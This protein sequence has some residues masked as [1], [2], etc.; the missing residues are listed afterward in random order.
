MKL[1]YSVLT[2]FLVL[3]SVTFGQE[4]VFEG[5]I[6]DQ[7]EGKKLSG[8]SVK[9]IA[10]GSVA[11]STTTSGNGG[12]TVKMPIGKI[13]KI[14][15]SKPGYVTKTMSIDLRG[16]NGEDIPI[17]GRIMP[18]VDIELFK[19]R[20]GVDF[21]FLENEPVVT[22]EYD[23]RSLVMDWDRKVYNKMKKKIDDLLA[24]ADAKSKEK[25]A[26]YNRLIQEADAL[27]KEEK[28]NEAL[29]KY[30]ESIKIKGKETEAHPN[31]RIIEIENILQKKAEEELANKQANQAYQNLLD[32]AENLTKNKEYD[33][34]I[35]KYNEALK[36]K[37]GEQFP[38]DK[39]NEIKDL[40]QKESAE[41]EYNKLITEAD[42]L[43]KESK[44]NEARAKYVAA[45]KLL[46]DKAYP[47]DQLKA[48][49]EK[50]A[51][52]KN[53]QENKAK[54]DQAVASA[55][56]LFKENKFQEAIVKYQEA[57]GY[58]KDAS[59]PKDQIRIAEE[60]ISK[61][62]ALKK[63]K[64]EFDKL[65]IQADNLVSSEQYEDA[66]KTYNEA[67]KIMS[68]PEAV[69]KKEAAVKK[70]EELKKDTEKQEKIALL[71][72]SAKVSF[73]NK[74]Y[75]SALTGYESVLALDKNN[76]TAIEGK[77]KT[78]AEI[79]KN[80]EAEAT[81]K[82]FDE[83]VSTGDELFRQEKWEESQKMYQEANNVIKDNDHV[84]KR[85]ED[86]KQK[87]ESSK[88]LAEQNKKIESLFNKAAEDKAKNNWDAAIASYEEILSIDKNN[89]KASN[90]L[91]ET[92]KA[93]ENFLADKKQQEE[94]DKLK[95]EADQLFA[96]KK[97]EEAK[98]KYLAARDIKS[99]EEIKGKLEIIDL[100][101][102]KLSSQKEKEEKYQEAMKKAADFEGNKEYA[103]ALE[104]YK[105][106]LAYKEN[107]ATAINKKKELELK[108]AEIQ[109]E[110]EREEK[111]QAALKEGNSAFDKEDYSSAIKAYD[112]ALEI[113]PNGAEAIEMK[114]K[115]KEK[116]DLLAKSEESYQQLLANAK[117]KY[118]AGKL[119]EAR[120]LYSQA[121]DAKPSDPIPQKAIVE[122]DEKLR[123]K[124]EADANLKE[125][126]EINKK[127][128][129]KLDLAEVAAQNFKYQEAV[130]HLKEASKL[131][132]SEEFPKKKIK[133]YQALIDQIAAQNN[134]E[135]K[136]SDLIDKADREF[137][138]KNYK[139]S[140]DLY[141]EALGVKENDDYANAQIKKAEEAMILAEKEG[142]LEKYRNIIA[143]ANQEF[144][145][146]NYNK[147]LNLYKEALS[148]KP[149]DKFASDR[150]SETQQIL[151][152][153]AKEESLASEEN[154][155]FN[156][157][158]NEADKLFDQK[159][160]IKAKEKYEEALRIK[161]NDAYAIRRVEES[162]Q[163][164]KKKVTTGDEERY[165]KILTKADEYFDEENYTKAKS[166]YERALKLRNYDKY[167]KD[168]LAEIRAI[169]NPPAKNEVA[170]ENL[171]E[172]EGIS[173][174]EG[175]A[176][177]EQA[178]AQRK[179]ERT[180]NVL[181]EIEKN[182]L[183]FKQKN[184]SDYEEHLAYQNEIVRIRDS[185][186]EEFTQEKE[187]RL[188]VA[189]EIEDMEFSI[190]EQRIQEN[191]YERNEHLRGNEELTYIAD[192]Y[193][194]IQSEK[195]K[196]SFN[197]AEEINNILEDHQ[198]QLREEIFL[199][200][201]N[202]EKT[203]EQ[204]EEISEELSEK[205][206]LSKQEQ[207]ETI[208]KIKE[209]ENEYEAQSRAEALREKMDTQKSNQQLEVVAENVRDDAL[210]SVE[211][212]EENVEKIKAIEE[213]RDIKSRTEEEQ[214]YDKIQNI[215]D[216]ALLAELKQD[217]S[218]DEKA[219]IQEQLIN[220]IA[221]LEG[222]LKRKK[223]EEERQTYEESLR[224][225]ALLDRASEQY[226]E[227]Q[228][229]KDDARQETVQ[230]ITALEEEKAEQER[231]AVNEEKEEH[232]NSVEY[233]EKI[234]QLKQE[235]EQKM[236]ED[237]L[238][239]NEEV[240][241]QEDLLNRSEKL[242]SDEEQY[243]RRKTVSEIE[244]IEQK[245]KNTHLD[246]EELRKEN[247]E[248][249]KA[250]ETSINAGKNIRL[251]EEKNKKL[252]TQSY[253]DDLEN[254]K[255]DFDPVIA[256]S[257]GEDFPEGVSQETYVRRD[258]DGL[259]VRIVTRRIV[260]QD[261][262]GEVYIRIQTRNA[263]T[264]SKNGQPITEASWIKGTEN[265]NLEHHF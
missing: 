175:M 189:A 231:L 32:A 254:G 127:Y 37:P 54:Y 213:A 17:G 12:Y 217:E 9:A 178:E 144:N 71:L 93:K 210:R 236:K 173:I 264:Y 122:I 89:T 244:L 3:L 38:V 21:S 41:K 63:Q 101:L 158:I 118:D 114:K 112:D 130:D 128:Q 85:L 91:D 75:Q 113:K 34:A 168:R 87:I 129:D 185:R 86:L 8:V 164:A 62:E 222:N 7:D 15:Y 202:T 47:K 79:A 103:Q 253:L 134:K 224:A 106:A 206:V 190:K 259:P 36:M 117:T 142:E 94:F 35:D 119:E 69:A 66:V 143:S 90:L 39:I 95:M 33:K 174:I 188:A 165:Q 251:E 68:T 182:E 154:K 16:I 260:V 170:L 23:E 111:Y 70:L 145:G 42:Q 226:K 241:R 227:S 29:A 149:G 186:T 181:N 44:W 82:K 169:L 18:P 77:K 187:E 263:V 10:D 76:L 232:I 81:K 151:D 1:K 13:Y 19:D 249:I 235:G 83:L 157:F 133:E 246:K 245:E 233:V 146:A 156:A 22:W 67:L 92:R 256:N 53:K 177:L 6:S 147:A 132:P 139:E 125:Q 179:A 167:P 258:K 57:L 208:E 115:A 161:S 5:K 255:T 109:K 201:A 200:R 140:I 78:E 239:L 52:E 211:M 88:K 108:L 11:Y 225:D 237:L 166:L 99:S 104:K 84:L 220:D 131:K 214:N 58:D 230:K 261:G 265:A 30:E 194:D 171:G 176:L 207:D 56:K 120:E 59:Y 65:I 136:F 49:D 60:N 250:M 204:L 193:L 48:I 26:E 240:K 195:S 74:D 27:F 4:V 229:D 205:A 123:K 150:I 80:K 116:I 248:T 184:L 121:Q 209:V 221:L 135:K 228:A 203:N 212:R 97:W 199:D 43:F 262:R 124:A 153:L 20:P 180:Q 45:S 55:D 102:S 137:M 198:V 28:Y 160:Y 234:N 197:N 191:M 216:Q 110:K 163:M 252:K 98:G 141:K 247:N 51:D 126:E 196:I 172:N 50:L 219:V 183:N 25:E 100:E 155:R 192:E 148:V 40:K 218:R 162:V 238:A 31:K 61:N 64:D 215:H 105:E 2:F 152:D 72:E 107:D 243:E 14:E 257:L 24:E 242:K 159:Q 223:S 73:E 138:A 96:Q 46:S